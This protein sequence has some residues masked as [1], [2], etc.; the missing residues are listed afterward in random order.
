MTSKAASDITFEDIFQA[1]V[2][3]YV[4]GDGDK[5]CMCS[6]NFGTFQCGACFKILSR[7]TFG[8]HY[9]SRLDEKTQKYIY[10]CTQQPT[11]D[12]FMKNKNK[13]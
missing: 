11:W 2:V 13:G 10:R 6:P 12:A 7:S 4:D 8:N 1:K 3:I 5:V 9:S